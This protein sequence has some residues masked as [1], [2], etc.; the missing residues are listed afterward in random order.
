MP[1]MEPRKATVLLPTL[2]PPF[3]HRIAEKRQSGAGI[4]QHKI[5]GQGSARLTCIE[6]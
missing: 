2:W 1:R 6:T 4:V 3:G 5:W